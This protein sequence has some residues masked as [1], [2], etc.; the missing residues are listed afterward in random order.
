MDEYSA[1]VK[2]ER[3]MIKKQ[4]VSAVS[5]MERKKIMDLQKELVNATVPKAV[6]LY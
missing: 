4:K 2:S 1:G 5:S 6:R 3:V